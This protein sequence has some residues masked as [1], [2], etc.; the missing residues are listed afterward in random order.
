MLCCAVLCCCCPRFAHEGILNCARAIR[1]DLDRLGLLDQLLLGLGASLNL[2]NTP[3]G[4]QDG[5]FGGK[6]QQQEKDADRASGGIG[7]D[8]AAAK[9]GGAAAAAAAEEG[10]FLNSEL[11]D[12]RGWT[13]VLTGHSLGE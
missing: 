9:A 10:R 12:C 5:G 13:L 11:P 8:G 2:N 4:G 3:P 1:D 7:V 6:Q